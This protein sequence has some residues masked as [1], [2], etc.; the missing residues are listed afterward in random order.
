MLLTFTASAQNAPRA[1][2]P[3]RCERPA[4][5]IVVD[6]GHTSE[7]PGAIS[8]RGETEYD[9]NLRLARE[10]VQQLIAAGFTNATLLITNGDKA[11]G[12]VQRVSR[13]NLANAQVLLSIHHDA[14]PEQF[15][16]DWDYEGQPRKFSDRFK[17]HSLFVSY[18]NAQRSASV[19]FARM[20]G[21]ALKE[22]GLQYA[23]HY[24][25]PFMGSRRRELV[26]K[27]TGIYRFDALYVLRAAGMPA[28][29]LEAGNIKNRDEELQLAATGHRALLVSS[30]VEAIGKF[31]DLRAPKKPERSA[32]R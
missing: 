26:D 16:E 9:Y 14:V 1:P 12:L 18:E 20:L 10:L 6:V 29:L 15:L 23:P 22:R 2:Q 7:I 3:Q 28:V 8:A 19:V 30:A 5:G 17:G 24:T 13:A 31:C 11:R 32:R 21:Q 27:V 4:F 25:E